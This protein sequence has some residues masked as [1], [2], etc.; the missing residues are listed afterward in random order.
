MQVTGNF[1][2]D[3]ELEKKYD[4]MALIEEKKR[5]LKEEALNYYNRYEPVHRKQVIFHQSKARIRGLLGGNRTGKTVAGAAEAVM[6]ATGTINR[7]KDIK[8]P[9]PNRGWVVSLSNEVQRDVAQREVLKWLPKNMIAHV[10]IRRGSKD[11]LDEAIIDTIKLT[12]G[13]TIQFK[14]CEQGVGMFQGTSR[15]WIWMDEEPPEDIWAECQ[16]RVMDTKGYM[17]LTMTPLLGLSWVYNR[18]YLNELDDPEVEC[19]S[20]QWSDNPHLSPEVIKHLESTM[21]DEEREA[22]QYG[23]FVALSGL[24]YKEFREDVHVIDPFDV[25][26][27][28]YDKLSI[29]PGYINA[30]SCHFY[31][32]DPEGNIYVIAE[33]YETNQNVE[34]HCKKIKEIAKKL[35]WPM[36]KTGKLRAIMDSAANQRTIAAE[37]SA[38]ELFMQFGIRGEFVDKSV[39][40]GI[41]RVKIF[42]TPREDKNKQVDKDGNLVWPNGKPRLFIFRTCPHMIREMK[43]YRWAENKNGENDKETPKKYNDHS[44][45]DLRYYV[46]SRPD[47][48]LLMSEEIRGH[49]HYRELVMK[50]FTD[51]QIRQLVNKGNVKLIGNTPS[52]RD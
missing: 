45:D 8:V 28:W 17:W 27:S 15:H 41:Q 49:Y 3:E 36:T 34:Y 38:T 47:P 14:S 20:M 24:I 26:K 37:K 19:F 44:M 2:Y 9:I 42:L 1:E 31:A 40:T 10:S 23:R 11:N 35:D 46:M 16:M 4:L 21:S 50:G 51:T 5:R 22:R 29:D 12:N 7:F 39:Y 32:C 48:A 43:N 30:T 6:M 18:I 33:H 25:P 52:R 13:S